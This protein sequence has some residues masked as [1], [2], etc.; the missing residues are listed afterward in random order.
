MAKGHNEPE[1]GNE[2][3]V[4]AEQSNVEQE[5]EQ[6]GNEQPQEDPQTDETPQESEDGTLAPAPTQTAPGATVSEEAKRT[7]SVIAETNQQKA[8]ALRAQYAPQLDAIGN[9]MSAKIRLLHDAGLSKGDISRVLQIQ[10]Q[11]VRNVVFN[12][13]MKKEKEARDAAAKAQQ[14]ASTAS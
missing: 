1:Q 7:P 14:P 11:F 3:Q 6:L 8:A 12:Y 5:L 10:F 4:D 2:P 13:D 9:N